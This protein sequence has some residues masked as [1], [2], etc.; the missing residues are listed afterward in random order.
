MRPIGWRAAPAA[1]LAVCLLALTASAAVA[2]HRS[3]RDLDRFFGH[4]GIVDLAS[5]LPAG[6]IPVD[7]AYSE[8]HGAPDG[9]TYY[10]ARVRR[11]E[12]SETNP[13]ERP[14]EEA[15]TAVV[16]LR[17]D[18]RLD[19]GF[20]AS[21]AL[22][23]ERRQVPD[24]I[25]V[26]ATGRLL[27]GGAN[28]GGKQHGMRL[29]RFLLSGDPDPRFGSGG[30]VLV[31]G[32]RYPDFLLPTASGGILVGSDWEGTESGEEEPWYQRLKAVRLQP[33]G[34]PDR[35][36]GEDG[37]GDYLLPGSAELSPIVA[38]G[39]GGAI[40]AAGD[41][42]CE[43]SL[44]Q[45]SRISARG[46]LDTGFNARARAVL[47]RFQR[48]ALYLTTTTILPR[49]NGEVDLLGRAGNG[50]GKDPARGFAL[51]LRR[52]GAIDSRYGHGGLRRLPHLVTAAAP[53]RA[54]ATFAAF[55]DA[56]R[57]SVLRLRRD[58]GTDRSFSGVQGQMLPVAGAGASLEPL[59]AGGA[60]LYSYGSQEA[61]K[62]V[63]AFPFAARL[64]E[65]ASRLRPLL[66][67]DAAAA[68]AGLDR[69]FG[70]N[71]VA[72]LKLP[73]TIA[74][75]PYVQVTQFAASADGA[76]FGISPAGGCIESSCDEGTGVFRVDPAGQIDSAFGGSGFVAVPSGAQDR[77]LAADPQGRPLIAALADETITVF[78]Y[79]ADGQ[80]D[81]TFGASGSVQLPC[82]CRLASLSLIAEA[83]GGVLVA[84]ELMGGRT[85]RGPGRVALTRLLPN[86]APDP[87]FGEGG[88]A[89]VGLGER[90]LP[91]SIAV[92]A[93][94]SV[95][96][97]AVGCCASPAYVLRVDAAGRLDSGF[98]RTAAS[99]LRRL[100]ALGEFSELT[101]LLPRADG[102]V[103]LIGTTQMNRGFDLRL[104]ADGRLARF[105]RKGVVRLPFY[106][107]A[108]ALGSDGAVFAVGYRKGV[109]S[110]R[111]FRLLR[112]G[113]LDPGFHGRSGLRVPV[114]GGGIA[115]AALGDGRAVV[116][117]LGLLRC[118]SGCAAE[119]SIARFFEGPHGG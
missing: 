22:I 27:T 92:G 2:G 90:P 82:A 16:R 97:G 1:L 74:S 17:P 42:C 88:Q 64:V 111:A 23:F 114:T 110:H 50:H 86:G 117:D 58:G 107:Y 73:S 47:L 12:K 59:A 14:C 65:P 80:P 101:T 21:G 83:D 85:G 112:D 45:V 93:D 5:T 103:D 11:C 38:L 96:L 99:S 49:A 15:A 48:K 28:Y 91:G 105:G 40:Y 37:F 76:T 104:R 63:P 62:V 24:L 18:G 71:G 118:R 66:G 20:G 9:A 29:R 34:R 72:H 79:T 102:A 52:N 70:T 106:V 10:S 77:V 69:S 4:G 8:V 43:T 87:A 32:I 35:R 13:G 44:T 19:R 25:A 51:R 39:P 61:G 41:L 55:Q 115:V 57:V 116:T 109:G 30:T 6:L 26:D 95:F 46:R 75:N 89:A 84:V 94:G 81:P 78:R 54:G 108:A 67:A 31:E 56:G 36:F 100:R 60:M 33:D 113:H 53:G 68:P 119:P 98:G 3:H 7:L